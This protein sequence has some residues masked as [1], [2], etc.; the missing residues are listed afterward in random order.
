M[1]DRAGKELIMAGSIPAAFPT[2]GARQRTSVRLLRRLELLSGLWRTR[3]HRYQA[4]GC[5]LAELRL[6]SPLCMCGLFLWRLFPQ[7]E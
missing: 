4:R 3:G 7:L 1:S 6:L 5:H 2:T